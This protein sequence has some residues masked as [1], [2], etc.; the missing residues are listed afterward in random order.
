MLSLIGTNGI[1]K[2]QFF[3]HL[4]VKEAPPP[5]APLTKKL[6]YSQNK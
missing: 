3:T 5:P 6:K 4:G 1:G 2:C